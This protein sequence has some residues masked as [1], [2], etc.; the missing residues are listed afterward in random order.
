MSGGVYQLQQHQGIKPWT[1]WRARWPSWGDPSSK[2]IAHDRR[3][4][5]LL[6][7]EPEALIQSCPSRS[8][9]APSQSSHIANP[10]RNLSVQS[11]ASHLQLCGY[12]GPD[13]DLMGSFPVHCGIFNNTFGLYPQDISRNSI[14]HP[15][16]HSPGLTTK[17]VSKH[18][19][20]LLGEARQPK[21]A[22][23]KG[24]K[25]LSD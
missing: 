7:E 19:Q 22:N 11:G 17:S 3:V 9:E 25:N 18:C 13:D 6:A 23:I 2:A 21:Q 24:M 20:I 1:F 5:T 14:P 15:Q 12:L 16:L 4:D 8:I 10:A